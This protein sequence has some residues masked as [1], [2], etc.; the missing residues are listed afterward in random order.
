MLHLLYLTVLPADAQPA[1][2]QMYSC[3]CED[4][5]ASL[6]S[7]ASHT[8][9]V[10]PGPCRIHAQQGVVVSLGAW[11]A[12][13]LAEQLADA[14]WAGAF[15]P[16]RGLLLEMPR[17][18]GMAPVRHGLMEMGYTK[19]R[20]C[21]AL[22][23]ANPAPGLTSQPVFGPALDPLS[24]ASSPPTNCLPHCSALTCS[25]TAWAAGAQEQQQRRRLATSS[26]SPSLPP[27]APAA[28]CWWAAAGSLRA[29]TARRQRRCLGPS[30]SERCSSCLAWRRCSG[31]TST[32]GRGPGR[33]PRL[34]SP[35][36]GPCRER[37][38]CWWQRGTRAAV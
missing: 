19:A 37:R 31:R 2:A 29:S 32:S 10:C 1:H 11:S 20:Q 30:C 21:S 35:G 6:S 3:P 33:M 26:T 13:F 34:A 16:R 4:G 28:R 9:H 22:L 23:V 5:H 15:R 36:W 27:P 14:R 17:P 18:P 7:L 38:V 25:T 12:A 24:V 8:R